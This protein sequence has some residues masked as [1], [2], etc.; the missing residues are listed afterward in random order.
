[1]VRH[2]VYSRVLILPSATGY[3]RIMPDPLDDFGTA[4]HE[5]LEASDDVVD[6]IAARNLHGQK[7][8]AD[9]ARVKAARA[10]QQA[11]ESERR[12]SR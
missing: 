7:T 8:A 6:E 5:L 1:M 2:I 12:R 10:I 3:H 4:Y 11:R 9:R